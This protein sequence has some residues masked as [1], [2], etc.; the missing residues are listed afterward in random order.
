MNQIAPLVVAVLCVK[1]ALSQSFDDLVARAAASAE[2]NRL[3]EAAALYRKALAQRPSWA[4]GW[5]KLG[6][7][8][9]DKDDFAGAAM[10]LGQATRQAPNVGVAW[11]MLGLAEAKLGRTAEALRHI[12][13]GRA[14]GGEQEGLRRV[15][16]YQQGLLLLQLGKF[17]EAQKVLDELAV[18]GADEE[19]ALLALGYSVLGILPQPA[20]D[21]ATR[22]V[23]LRAGRAEYLAARRSDLEQAQREYAQLAGDFPTTH[24]VQFAYGRFLLAQHQDDEAVR[25]FEREIKNSP[26]H[27][28]ARLG[29]AGVKAATDPAGGLP[30]AREA[31]RLAPN[32]A[33][34]HYLVGLLLLNSG[35][36][37]KAIPELEQARRLEPGHA[38]VYFQLG[39]AY[40]AVG[41][42]EDAARARAEFQR[43]RS[44]SH[45]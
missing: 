10:A 1:G 42:S 29:I 43:L 26:N 30:Y 13:R 40:A 34:S 45:D 2:A 37:Q 36:T 9:Y 18:D 15:M 33:E 31:L 39:R 7:V 14:L 41:R 24:N 3:D 44:A 19:E 11:V 20:P 17:G 22:Q 4:E 32:L 27:V 8:L 6:T 25:A 35:E 12:E 23:A 21:P 38:E 28:L 16:L 5:W